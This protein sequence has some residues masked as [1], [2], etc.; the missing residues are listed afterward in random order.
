MRVP[1]FRG[2]GIALQLCASC[3]FAQSGLPKLTDITV[4]AGIDFVHNF[5]DDEMSNLIES[6][7]AGCAFFDYDN[8]GDLD[9]Y[10]VNG[11]YTETVSHIK[12]RKNRG[13]LSKSDKFF[14]IKVSFDSVNLG[15]HCDNGFFPACCI[16]DCLFFE[17]VFF[18]IKPDT[19]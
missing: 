18:I 11:A 16:W 5:G 13:K 10:L 6:N 4:Q 2:V 12:G 8:D 7:A 19:P 9:V 15:F 17:L 14:L 3:V 1:F